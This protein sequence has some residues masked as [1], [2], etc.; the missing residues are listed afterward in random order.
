MCVLI[1]HISA[2]LAIL[3]QSIFPNHSIIAEHNNNLT[4]VK[5]GQGLTASGS[6][7]PGKATQT[8]QMRQ[9]D[10]YTDHEKDYVNTTICVWVAATQ[11]ILKT[12]CMK[13]GV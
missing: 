8:G 10:V 13:Q 3:T 4:V 9:S 12:A 5:T 1:L 2:D 6:F 11:S 7:P